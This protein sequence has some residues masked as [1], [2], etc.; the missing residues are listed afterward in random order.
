MRKSSVIMLV[1]AI[2]LAFLALAFVFFP[3]P[4]ITFFG[5]KPVT[6]VWIRILGYILGA[7]SFFYLMAIRAEAT[8]FF[9]W[10]VYARLPIFIVFLAFVVLDLA[11]PILLAFGVFDTGMGILTG[12]ALR[13]EDR[14]VT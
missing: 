4:I 11:P 5:F 3:N 7:L 12:L 13:K 6:A 1:F 10:T 8:N 14:E 9:L 2:Y